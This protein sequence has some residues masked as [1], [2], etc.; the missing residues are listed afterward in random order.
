MSIVKCECCGRILDKLNTEPLLED[1]L[2]YGDVPEDEMVE[3]CEDCYGLIMPV[4][5]N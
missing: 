2:L 3:V 4:G 5:M 1:G